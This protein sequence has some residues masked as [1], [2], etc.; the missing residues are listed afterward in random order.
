MGDLNVE[1]SAPGCFGAASVFSHDSNVCKAC[2]AFEE[3]AKRSLQRLEDI[4]GIVNV[5]DLLMKHARAQ[6]GAAAVRL[7][8]REQALEQSNAP[9]VTK[10]APKQPVERKTTVAKVTF[11]IDEDEQAVIARIGNKK[12]QAQAIVL[13][14][15]NLIQI[16]RQELSAGRNP[17]A[18]TGPRF[19]AV[20]CDLLIGGGFTKQALKQAL[21]DRLEW[22]DGTASSHVSIV[23]ALFDAFSIIKASGEGYVFSPDSE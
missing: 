8:R 12:A 3:C 4:K 23:C 22:T 2:P 20:A 21:M 17:F 5:S 14:K 13:C 15:S 16:A 18:D 1:Q 11:E 6:K 9:M 19:I 10:P 7:A